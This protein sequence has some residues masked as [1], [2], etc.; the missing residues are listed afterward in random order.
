VRRPGCKFDELPVLESPT[1]GTDKSTAIRTLAVRWD[2]F[3]DY[4]PL[5]ADP[6]VVIEQTRGKWIVEAGELSGMRKSD[7]DKLKGLLSR[8]SDRGRL[9]YA[10]CTSEVQRQFIA[11][12]T[13]NNRKYLSAVSST[14][15][16][17]SWSP[18]SMSEEQAASGQLR[19]SKRLRVRQNLSPI[20]SASGHAQLSLWAGFEVPAT[21]RS[22]PS[23]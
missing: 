4:L 6:K 3:T 12:G 17:T 1:Q 7:I 21:A 2:W 19:R 13:T 11:I 9:A 23:L 15:L 18:S 16:M 5:N 20:A 10:R 22:A 8:S 14:G